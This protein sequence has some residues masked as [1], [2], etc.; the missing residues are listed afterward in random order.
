MVVIYCYLEKET[1][2]LKFQENNSFDIEMSA[3][4]FKR[5]SPI[6]TTP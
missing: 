5:H 4:L 1:K 6:S 2:H 3:S